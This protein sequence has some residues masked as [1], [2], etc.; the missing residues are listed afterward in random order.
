[1]RRDQMHRDHGRLGSKRAKATLSVAG[2]N[3]TSGQGSMAAM[4]QILTH[5]AQQMPVRTD[6][7]SGGRL[8]NCINYDDASSCSPLPLCVSR[9]L[10]V[11]LNHLVGI[12]NLQRTPSAAST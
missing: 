6:P 3:P 11:L 9:R 7:G 12:S 8:C 2:V 10:V 4:C 1:M 5:A